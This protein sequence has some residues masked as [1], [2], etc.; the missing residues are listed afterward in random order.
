MNIPQRII[1]IVTV[2]LLI[3]T[4]Y[5]FYTISQAIN[6]PDADTKFRTSTIPRYLIHIDYANDI[7]G[8]DYYDVKPMYYRVIY[9]DVTIL[10]SGL[11]LFWATKSNNTTGNKKHHPLE[12]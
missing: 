5:Y 7:S 2:V 11:L 8:P 4:N 9:I 1:L 3:I 6:Q 10:I 12:K